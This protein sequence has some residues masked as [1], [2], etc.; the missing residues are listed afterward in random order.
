MEAIWKGNHN[1]R[2]RNRPPMV[3]HVS[4]RPGRL[5]HWDPRCPM[6]LEYLPTFT[7]DIHPW[8]LTWHWKIGNTSSNGRLFIVMLVFGRVKQ[9]WINIP[10]MEQMGIRFLLWK[11]TTSQLCIQSALHSSLFFLLG[12]SKPLILTSNG[13]SQHCE[14]SETT[15]LWQYGKSTNLPLRTPRI[16]KVL[17][18]PFQG[19]LVDSKP[20][21]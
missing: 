21:S 10:Y 3:S 8:K 5:P 17:I 9:I 15:N 18:K 14:I 1:P 11:R 20:W 2:G 6:G 13:T 7:T 4:V 19:K 16:N 12:D